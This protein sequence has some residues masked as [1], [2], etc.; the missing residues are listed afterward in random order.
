MLVT[1]IQ[2]SVFFVGEPWLLQSGAGK[3][4]DFE[5]KHALQ[6]RQIIAARES[7]PKHQGFWHSKPK[8]NHT[9]PKKLSLST[10]RVAM[11]EHLCFQRSRHQEKV[12]KQNSDFTLIQKDT[13]CKLKQWLYQSLHDY[14]SKSPNP[15]HTTAPVEQPHAQQA[16]E[17]DSL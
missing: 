7:K 3:G 12:E 9:K 4:T 15:L 11:F 16:Q 5:Q 2:S 14:D 10:P 17:Q 13:S 6:E 8:R 1:G